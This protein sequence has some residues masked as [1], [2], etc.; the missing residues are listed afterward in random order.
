MILP[1]GCFPALPYPPVEYS[2]I[3]VAVAV[4]QLRGS[5]LDQ[6]AVKGLGMQSQA[7]KW[8]SAHLG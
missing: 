5:Q 7:S 8:R 2:A 4:Q 1:G 6:R 3:V